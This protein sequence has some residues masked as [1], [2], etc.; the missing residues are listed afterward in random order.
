MQLARIIC[1]IIRL[2]AA[3]PKWFWQPQCLPVPLPAGTK[4]SDV[5]NDF[6]Y[7]HLGRFSPDKKRMFSELPWTTL[8]SD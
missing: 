7:W 4:F 8:T 3:V 5:A 1:E 6:G 2:P